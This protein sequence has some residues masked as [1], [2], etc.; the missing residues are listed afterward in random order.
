M[1]FELPLFLKSAMNSNNIFLYFAI[2]GELSTWKGCN[3]FYSEDDKSY[4]KITTI[5]NE[6]II[7]RVVNFVDIAKNHFLI[8]YE[9]EFFVYIDSENGDLINSTTNEEFLKYKNLAVIGNEIVSFQ[10]I[11]K[12]DKN[13]YKLKTLSRGRFGTEEDISQHQI[14]ERFI[15]LDNN[16]HK[17]ELPITSTG[18]KIFIKIVS[19]GQTLDDID[20][21]EY[22]ING[23][24]IMPLDPI[25]IQI[26]TIENNQKKISWNRR[27][28]MEIDLFRVPSLE[29]K[30]LYDVMLYKADNSLIKTIFDISD[31]NFIVDD[32]DNL[33]EKAIIKQKSY[34]FK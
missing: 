10:T 6:S 34:F 21:I 27:E 14:N 12:V 28:R 22:T 18:S 31:D 30:E 13:L 29:T 20:S 8:D 9:S 11:I 2:S 19:F 25:N 3:I 32:R 4:Q 16:L 24:S 26:K 5:E 17:I 33:I 7:G 23:K 15:M 1:I